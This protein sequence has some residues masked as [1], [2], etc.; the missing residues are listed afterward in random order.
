M[1]LHDIVRHVGAGEV[2][3]GGREAFLPAPGHSR[4][5]RGVHLTLVSPEK[6]LWSAFNDSSISHP[7]MLAYL[8][9]D[10]TQVAKPDKAE[11]ARMRA[12]RDAERRRLEAE[13]R[14]FCGAIWDATLPIEGTPAEAFLYSRGLMF[15]G[16]PV[17]RWHPSAPRSKPRDRVAGDPPPPLPHAGMVALVS[18]VTGAPKALHITYLTQDGRKA[19]GD[20]SRL[21]FGYAAGAAVRLAPIGPDGVLAVAEGVETAGSFAV[22]HGVPCWA[23]LSTSGL[24]N[25]VVPSRVRRLLVAA[26]CDDHGAGIEAAR[27][28][29]E[30]ARRLCDVEVHPAPAGQD[31]NDA[32]RAAPMTAPD[33]IEAPNIQFYPV[34]DP[35]THSWPESCEPE[36]EEWLI[37]GLVP[38]RSYV[39]MF[40]RRGAAKSF[41]ALDWVNRA[42]LGVKVFGQPVEAFGTIYFVGEKKSRFNKRVKAWRIAASR[43]PNVLHV[44]GTINLLDEDSLRDG[45]AFINRQRA[46]F[47]AR[48]VRLGMVV[49]DTLNKA[50]G[51]ANDS[52][53]EVAGKGT[54]AIQRIID[55]CAVTVMPTHH[56]AK[57]KEADTARGAGVWE[58]AADSIVRIDREADSAVRKITLTKQSDEA[59]GIEYAFRLEV[60]E[61]GKTPK[62]E[63]IS[64]CIVRQVDVPDEP[65][66]T[67]APKLS[68]AAQ[69]IMQAFNRLY[70][71][72]VTEPAPMVPGVRQGTKAVALE[73]LRMKA[74]AI[75][76]SAGASPPPGADKKAIQQFDNTRNKAW[77]DGLAKLEELRVLRHE[78]GFVWALS[79]AKQVQG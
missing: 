73:T 28:L 35:W 42:S 59:D 50:I 72:G 51:G 40:G 24:Q 43:T 22:L 57:S 4:R 45:I 66:R 60:V 14:A 21:I 15:E 2:R 68:A 5:D 62:G 46:A 55:E 11:L 18:D 20:R 61:V 64:S 29:A 75:G 74:I 48:G 44:W 3:A 56:M 71:D 37:P 8:G 30:R 49:F 69:K 70:D 36:A 10:D 6:V 16:C 17:L 79:G 34:E 31:W 12:R 23:A 32:L 52:D 41:L 54:Y 47:E 7:D 27:Q 65:G 13:S 58:D 1:D 39:L 19:F 76:L 26:D 53:F 33:G 38:R 77:R 25:F 9:I 63:A 67:R 78:N